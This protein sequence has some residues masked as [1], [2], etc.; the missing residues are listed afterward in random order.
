MQPQ[1]LPDLRDARQCYHY[2]SPTGE[3]CGSPSTKNEYYCYF[4]SIKNRRERKLIDPD[5]TCM[6]LPP[7]EDRS[8]IFLALAAVVHR[9]AANTID[10][11][12][13]GQMIYAL[14]T[15]LQAL[16][17]APPP[18]APQPTAPPPAPTPSGP[19]SHTCQCERSEEPPQL[20]PVATDTIPAATATPPPKTILI[21]KESL[22]YF[23]RSRHCYNCNAELF[24]PEELTER[25]HPGAPPHIIEEN[26]FIRRRTPN[27][28]PSDPTQPFPALTSPGRKSIATTTQSFAHSP[29]PQLRNPPPNIIRTTT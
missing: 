3:R 8:S 9:L 21:T 18:L 29:L 11:R 16:P 1:P 14:Q 7:I 10:T 26:D 15:A 28:S 17:P 2:Q 5:I 22:V 20:S 24:P 4:H 6:E 25:A 19:H 27:P 23:L 12:R 13:A